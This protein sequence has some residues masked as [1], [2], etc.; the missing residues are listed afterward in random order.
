MNADDP[1]FDG[2]P[3]TLAQFVHSCSNGNPARA[4]SS[5]ALTLLEHG[6]TV[7]S[8]TGSRQCYNQLQAIMLSL[9]SVSTDSVFSWD[10]P[11]GGAA[12][13]ETAFT[14]FK[15]WHAT[16]HA[17]YATASSASASAGTLPTTARERDL[18][19]KPSNALTV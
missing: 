4:L 13:W 11:P 18:T 8:K 5:D 17:A 2:S 15:T 16:Q 19:L 3:V 10:N 14:T 1:R 7:N 9:A 12:W 6:F